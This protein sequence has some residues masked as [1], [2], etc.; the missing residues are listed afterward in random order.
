M[1]QLLPVCL[2][3]FLASCATSFPPPQAV[4]Q[5][6]PP[7][8]QSPAPQE[9]RQEIQGDDLEFIGVY[10]AEAAAIPALAAM[11]RRDLDDVRR[12]GV[13]MARNDR[14]EAEAAGFPFRKHASDKIW[15]V[16]ASGPRFLVLTAEIYTFTGGAHGMTNFDVLIW[17][18]EAGARLA[19]ADLLVP[20]ADFSGLV[21]PA[22]CK[23]LD[24]QREQKRG[25]PVGPSGEM[26]N[27]CLDPLKQVIA[28]AGDPGSSIDHIDFLIAP[29]EAGPYAEGAYAVSLPL[30]AAMLDLIRPKY[31]S[32]FSAIRNGR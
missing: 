17:D 2:S 25:A 28:P 8:S 13:R 26:F 16:R 29:Y 7:S 5:A 11:L 19:F 27:T 9:F 24:H 22:F 6:S 21:Q 3:A 4:T 32:A 30:T 15:S 14:R 31:R 1:R 23:A 10:P 12:E 18:R 20:G